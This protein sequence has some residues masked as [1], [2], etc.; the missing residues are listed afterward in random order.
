M[1]KEVVLY[2]IDADNAKARGQTWHQMLAEKFLTEHGLEFAIKD[3]MNKNMF[4][5]HKALNDDVF[6]VTYL[7]DLH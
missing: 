1:K 3:F 7:G 6:K 2:R 5:Y 4:A